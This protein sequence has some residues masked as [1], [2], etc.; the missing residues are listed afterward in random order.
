MTQLRAQCTSVLTIVFLHSADKRYCSFDIIS[1]ASTEAWT[2]VH[3]G[4]TAGTFK[5]S[6][7]GS[8]TATTKTTATTTSDESSTTT[9]HETTSTNPSSGS[10]AS[11]TGAAATNPEAK[12]DAAT[13]T[14]IELSQESSSPNSSPNTGAIVGGVIGGLVLVCGTV[15][16]AIYLLRRNNS[17]DDNSGNPQQ[18]AGELKRG[19]SSWRFS[20]KTREPSELAGWGPRE[21]PGSDVPG[22]PNKEYDRA[23]AVELPA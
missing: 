9:G 6:I 11:E 2:W 13:T 14:S 17:R 1:Y 8:I 19:F 4:T 18:Q 10:S 21:L 20:R 12:T 7:A 3:C 5:Y 16:A 23:N 15:I 22:F